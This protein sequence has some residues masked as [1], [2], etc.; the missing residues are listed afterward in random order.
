MKLTA[1]ILSMILAII[2]NGCIYSDTITYHKPSADG[3]KSGKGGC[4]PSDS[5]I[6][7]TL[8][9]LPIQANFYTQSHQVALHFYRGSWKKFHFASKDFKIYDLDKK[10]T[11][12]PSFSSHTT[13]KK[14]IQYL[15]KGSYYYNTNRGIPV[16]IG[17]RF[18]GKV[19]DNF[20]LLCP[21]IVIDGKKT[22]FPPI[23]FNRA[24]WVGF[25]SMNC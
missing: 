21:P 10:R 1:I 24:K 2:L 17:L 18:P 4:E 22:K 23:H 12:Y 25:R 7:L 14:G 6:Y 8:R 16:Y 5:R 9:N 19:P 3:A 15:K 20:I 11:I 13:T